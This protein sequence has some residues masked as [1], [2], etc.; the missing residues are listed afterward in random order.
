[1]EWPYT[2]QTTLVEAR[3]TA[4]GRRRRDLEEARAAGLS[5]EE[6]PAYLAALATYDAMVPVWEA[7]ERVAELAALEAERER[8][9]DSAAEAGD[10]WSR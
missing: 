8:L 5:E 10:R 2:P 1:M 6:L 7:R 4:E 9:E 3:A